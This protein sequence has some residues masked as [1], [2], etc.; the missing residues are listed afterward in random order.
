MILCRLTLRASGVLETEPY[1]GLRPVVLLPECAS[2]VMD[3]KEAGWFRPCV[4]AMRIL[5]TWRSAV[6]A[7]RGQTAPG[8]IR[9]YG[10]VGAR[11][12]TSG[13]HT[14][15][16]K[17][18]SPVVQPYLGKT[19]YLPQRIYRT[20]AKNAMG[21]AQSAL[22]SDG[23]RARSLARVLKFPR[24]VRWVRWSGSFRHCEASCLVA[25]GFKGSFAWGVG[26]D[27]MDFEVWMWLDDRLE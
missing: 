23:H 21:S 19:R 7:D 3:W 9:L 13:F 6:Y 20:L 24:W 12:V 14:V 26:G 17:M 27:G 5:S 16:S 8:P 4:M 2:G 22:R 1:R 11:T 15:P 18:Y 25:E 10:A